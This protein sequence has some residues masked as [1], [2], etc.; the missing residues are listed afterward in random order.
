MI[1][2]T[3]KNKILT[4]LGFVFFPGGDLLMGTDQP[5]PCRLEGSRQNETPQRQ[6]TVGPFWLAKCCVSN[7]DF[8]RFKPNHFRP[9]TASGDRD[10][11]TDLTYLEA[12]DYAT[13]LSVQR[14]LEFDLPTEAE[15]TFAA[16]P[17]GWS[18]SYQAEEKPNPARAHT[19]NRESFHALPV[20]DPYFVNGFG[21]HHMSGNVTEMTKGWYYA[22]G[23][24]GAATDGAYFMTKGG[25]F[26]H[27]SFSTRI[28]VRMI[29]DVVGRSNRVGFRLAGH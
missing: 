19:F 11:V 13:W 29:M 12:L 6:M 15:W 26:G 7:Q 9:P 22:P 21:L 16:A 2:E 18:F 17:R 4:D 24:F 10:P 3:E 8:E 25:S 5:L 20:D 27:C 28:C 14:G 23:H 1:T